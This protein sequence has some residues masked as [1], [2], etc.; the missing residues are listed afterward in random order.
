MKEGFIDIVNGFLESKEDKDWEFSTKNTA[1][2][3][4]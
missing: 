4:G 1:G 2:D 3:F